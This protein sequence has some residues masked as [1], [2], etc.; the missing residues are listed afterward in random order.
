MNVNEAIEYIHSVYWQ[1][2]TPG[3]H[4]V[5]ALLEKMGNPEKNLKYVHIAGT[6]GKGSTA[7][8]TASILQKAGYRTGLYTSPYIYR[9]HERIQV[10][11]QQISDEDL[12]EITE[13]VKPLASS[14]NPSPTEFELVCC[15]AFE[16]FARKQCDVVVLEVGLGG[17]FDATNVID[18]PKWRSSPTSAWITLTF[19]AT[20]WKKL[21]EP[22]PVSSRKAATPW[23]TVVSP[24]WSEF[25]RKSVPK[26]M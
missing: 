6:N 13:M 4:R 22:K 18:T 23:F 10:D 11:G 5:Q 16:Y 8:M 7:S 19:W 20:L 14:M 1:G 3:L 17:A 12:V 25:L 21:P 26:K 9:F 15:I 2:S 24:V